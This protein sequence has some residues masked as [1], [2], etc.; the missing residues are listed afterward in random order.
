MCG[1]STVPHSPPSKL[2]V[3]IPSTLGF[4]TSGSDFRI[5][6][7]G[8]FVG[9]YKPDGAILE[10]PTGSHRIVVELPSAYQ[11]RILPNGSAEIRT[12]SLRGEERIEIFGGASQQTLVFNSDNLKSREVENDS[13]P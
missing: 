4:E 3:Q 12:F 1:C 8:H 6:V 9:N 10:L 13:E 2:S 5:F 11:R 7:D